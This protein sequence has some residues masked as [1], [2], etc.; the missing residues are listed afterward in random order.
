MKGKAAIAL[1]ML[2]PALET[3]AGIAKQQSARHQR[4]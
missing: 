2:M 3:I 1:R 4:R